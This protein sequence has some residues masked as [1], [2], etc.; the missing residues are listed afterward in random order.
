M[1]KREIVDDLKNDRIVHSLESVNYLKIDAENFIT[2][3][4]ADENKIISVFQEY[5]KEEPGKKDSG[6]DNNER[7][8][9]YEPILSIKLHDLS[10]RELLLFKSLY[11]SKT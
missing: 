10:L 7:E 8:T 5:D 3:E 1:Q 11:V 6:N 2:F 4:C 9:A